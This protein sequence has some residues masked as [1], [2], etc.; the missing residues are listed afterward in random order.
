[1]NGKLQGLAKLLPQLQPHQPCWYPQAAPT[2][3]MPLV[4]LS[5]IA[6]HS[7][8][9]KSGLG[10][11]AGAGAGTPPEQTGGL[12]STLVFI[13]FQVIV[14]LAGWLKQPVGLSLKALLPLYLSPSLRAAAAH[15][16]SLVIGAEPLGQ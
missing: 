13:E 3:G 15:V 2:W 1:M 14:F 11:G 6:I 4:A 12:L 9:L 16:D 10:P 8:K 7:S 5:Y